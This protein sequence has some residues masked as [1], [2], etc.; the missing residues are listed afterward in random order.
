MQGHGKQKPIPFETLKVWYAISTYIPS[1]KRT[2]TD[3]LRHDCNGTVTMRWKTI[4]S[5]FGQPTEAA[6]IVRFL[7]IHI[8]VFCST[9]LIFFV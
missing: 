2:L 8:R 6:A 9:H 5:G 1:K 7:P 3:E 4:R